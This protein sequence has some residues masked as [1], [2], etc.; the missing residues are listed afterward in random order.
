MQIYIYMG[1]YILWFAPMF[2]I[3]FRYKKNDWT[4]NLKWCNDAVCPAEGSQLFNNKY[5]KRLLFSAQMFG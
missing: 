5:L 3:F 2:S 4:S 1:L